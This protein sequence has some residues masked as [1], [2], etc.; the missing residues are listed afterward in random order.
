MRQLQIT[1][2]SDGRM[3]KRKLF[4]YFSL[5]LFLA[6]SPR[7][8]ALDATRDLSDSETR[9]LQARKL[10]AVDPAAAIAEYS[11]LLASSFSVPD[12]LHAALGRLLP[13]ADALI[14]WKAVAEAKPLSPFAVEALEQLA[15]HAE[16]AGLSADAEKHLSKLVEIA[17]DEEIEV[18]ALLRLMALFDASGNHPKALTTAEKVWVDYAHMPESKAAEAVLSRGN[19]DPFRPVSGERIFRR[20]KNL[21]EKGRRDQAIAALEKLKSRLIP[22][23]KIEPELN[24]ILGKAN[25][26]LRQ[27]QEAIEPLAFAAKHNETRA[28]AGFYRGR[29]LFGLNRGDEGAREFVALARALPNVGLAPTY[30]YQAYKVFQGRELWKEAENARKLLL[31]RYPGSSEARDVTWHDGWRAFLD[32]DYSKAAKLF[33]TSSDGAGRDWVGARGVYWQGRALFMSGQKDEGTTVLKALLAEY[34]L[35]YYALLTKSLLERGRPDLYLPDLRSAGE[36]D[37]SF[38][39][40][41]SGKLPDGES[42]ARIA[43]YLKLELFDAARFL[44]KRSGGKG[45]DWARLFCWAEDYK[46]A[47]KASGRSWL[48]WP[49]A[50]DP[51]IS[52]AVGL[53]FPLAY[54]EMV[55]NAGRDAGIHPHLVLAIGH[56]ESNFEARAY[57]SFEARGIMQFMPST[58]AEVAKAL[59][60]N[61]FEP[62]DLFEPELALKLGSTHLRQLLD[63]FDGN[64]IAA[65]AAYNGGAAAVSRWLEKWGKSDVDVFVEMIQYRE[66]RRYV[67]KVV[68]ALDAYAR[69][70][71]PGVWA[72]TE[73]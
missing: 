73:H 37:S 32:N 57:S 46:G 68:T 9:F 33:K 14:H 65:T 54:P 38:F 49:S 25:Y 18:R 35:G 67:K 44:L 27:Y 47:I 39:N 28:N 17:G 48:D 4:I 52:D 61:D 31:D 6:H 10:E 69:L 42:A 40:G 2:S 60:L 71:P 26:F 20:G 56:T 64:V 63:K 34:P 21:F 59:G 72:A 51:S 43:S 22:G 16:T 29:S 8:F 50:E 70:Y 30:L 15:S 45:A 7:I 66:T 23:S 55:H 19:S 5:I 58:G 12:A 24:L 36:V 1:S 53:A 41:K 62:E 13:P 3:F 11:A